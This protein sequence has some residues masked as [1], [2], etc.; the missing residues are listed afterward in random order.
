M[1]CMLEVLTDTVFA[2][3]GVENLQT[4][5]GLRHDNT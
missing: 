2:H 3:Q 1:Q 4:A 5:K